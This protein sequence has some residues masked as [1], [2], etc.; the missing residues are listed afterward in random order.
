MV[1]FQGALPIDERSSTLFAAVL[2]CHH[3]LW[4]VNIKMHDAPRFFHQNHQRKKQQLASLKSNMAGTSAIGRSI[5][6]DDFLNK[7]SLYKTL[8]LEFPTFYIHLH[9]FTHMFPCFFSLKP[10]LKNKK[11]RRRISRAG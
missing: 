2:A 5:S 8:I 7:N 11:H 10:P 6:F 4:L 3:M 1:L 9:T